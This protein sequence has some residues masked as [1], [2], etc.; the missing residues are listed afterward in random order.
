LVGKEI[1]QPHSAHITT[2]QLSQYSWPVT[3]FSA[4]ISS[5]WEP[6]TQQ[7]YSECQSLSG[8]PSSQSVGAAAML[9]WTPL[10]SAKPFSFHFLSTYKWSFF[11]IHMCMNN[12]PYILFSW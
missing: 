7:S 6:P 10:L 4:K 12:F 5:L 3:V 8:L 9:H 2:L 1:L 11:C